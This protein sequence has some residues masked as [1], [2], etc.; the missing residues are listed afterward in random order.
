MNIRPT[1][2]PTKVK[3]PIIAATNTVSATDANCSPTT[4]INIEYI[5]IINPI[6][7]NRPKIMGLISLLSP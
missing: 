6:K 5:R 2:V 1:I 7:A 3:D 4:P